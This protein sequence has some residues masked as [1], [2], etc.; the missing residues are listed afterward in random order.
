MPHATGRAVLLVGQ[1]ALHNSAR[2]AQANTVILQLEPL[3]RLWRL[4]VED[5]GRG[6]GEKDGPTSGEGFG[7]ESMR[8]RA[9]EI[10]AML[11]IDGA[12]GNGTTVQLVFDP[13]ARPRDRMNIRRTWRRPWDRT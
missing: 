2:H 7:L 6:V 11:H 5:D 10:G 13:R 8:R 9:A 1:E 12:D 3:G 4:T